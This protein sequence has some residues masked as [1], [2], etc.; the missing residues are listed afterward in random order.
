MEPTLPIEKKPSSPTL[1]PTN[2]DEIHSVLSL[3]EIEEEDALDLLSKV[4]KV[5]I[6][7]E[8]VDKYLELSEKQGLSKIL[9]TSL[10]FI[11]TAYNSTK[12][13]EKNIPGLT[14]ETAL[15]QLSNS[16]IRTGLA[17]HY[18]TQKDIPESYPPFEWD[19]N[20]ETVDQ[21][22][23]LITPEIRSQ[24][25]SIVNNP[26]TTPANVSLNDLPQI[27]ASICQIK[28]EAKLSGSN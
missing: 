25:E 9:E 11:T 13:V 2:L 10:S 6:S 1:P 14:K 21:V 18:L 15:D 27:L 28:I 5:N 22:K 26:D 8:R 23:K 24:A 17:I 16:V 12:L 3:R 7:R 4:T 19:V 20:Q